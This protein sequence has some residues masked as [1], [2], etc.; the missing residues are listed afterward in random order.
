[1]KTARN[2][3]DCLAKEAFGSYP[4]IVPV[5]SLSKIKKMVWPLCCKEG[6]AMPLQEQNSN[7]ECPAYEPVA[8]LITRL[9]PGDSQATKLL[10]NSILDFS[11]DFSARTAFLKGPIGAGKSTIARI[12]SFSKRL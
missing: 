8:K 5:V 12:I 6:S 1:M 11:F 9:L 10:R 2:R 3:A 4:Q 7:H